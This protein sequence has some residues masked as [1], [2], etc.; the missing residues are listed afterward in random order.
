M[1]VL[2]FGKM[3]W[4]APSENVSSSMRK[5][6][7]IPRMRK[8]SSGHLLS[9]DT[10]PVVLADS[11][12]PDQTARMRRLIWAFAVRTCSKKRYGP[13]KGPGYTA[14]FH[15]FLQGRQ[16]LLF[17]GCHSENGST[18]VKGNSFLLEYTPSQKG[19]KAIANELS[20]LKVYPFPLNQYLSSRMSSLNSLECF[21]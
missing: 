19:P 6:S 4:A 2:T 11:E 1:N 13:Y 21:Q 20:P 12:G 3:I 7:V 14:I 9:I 8:V 18:L 10:C 16:L 17:P 5:N 15:H